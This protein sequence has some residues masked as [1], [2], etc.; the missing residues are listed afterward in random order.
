ISEERLVPG[1]EDALYTVWRERRLPAG[2]N[3]AEVSLSDKMERD[4][5]GAMLEAGVGAAVGYA[6]PAIRDLDGSWRSSTWHFVADRMFLIPGDSPMGLRL[7]LSL[8][9]WRIPGAIG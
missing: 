1:Y 3:P 4:R 2:H 5:L 6:L 9:P 8:Q 7:P